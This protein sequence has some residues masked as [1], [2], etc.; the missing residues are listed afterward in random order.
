MGSHLELQRAYIAGF[1]DGDGSL[2]LQIKKR[3]DSAR[4]IRF[5]AT[6]CLYQDTRHEETLHWIQT[7]FGIGYVSHRNDGITELRVNGYRQVLT[8]LQTLVPYIRFK[9]VQ[10]KALVR[11]CQLLAGRKFSTLTDWELR[12]IVDLMLT[13]Q[14]ENYAS[15]RKSS[16]STLLTQLGLT[17]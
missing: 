1:L 6:I 17:P 14:H 9:R 2:M 12:S 7:V 10:A 11:A 4:G 13:I 15:H 5:M 8:I 3:K 16:Q